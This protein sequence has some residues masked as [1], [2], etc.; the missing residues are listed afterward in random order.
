MLQGLMDECTGNTAANLNTT[1][2]I[3][4]A[5]PSSVSTNSD[6]YVNTGL[7]LNVGRLPTGPNMNGMN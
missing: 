5:S 2:G 1:S 4:T 3:H 7:G 6:S